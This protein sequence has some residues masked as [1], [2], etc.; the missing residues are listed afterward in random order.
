MNR[1]RTISAHA[2]TTLNSSRCDAPTSRHSR[3]RAHAAGRRGDRHRKLSVGRRTHPRAG[4][5]VMMIAARWKLRH[6]AELAVLLVLLGIAALPATGQRPSAARRTPVVV[7][8]ILYMGNAAE[9][10]AMA[11]HDSL[12]QALRM[13]HR[14]GRCIPPVSSPSRPH[15][16]LFGTPTQP[17]SREPASCWETSSCPAS[18]RRRRSALR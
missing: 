4:S 17:A 6:L 5:R 8:S 15:G 14:T 11:I 16:K 18:R 7:L 3:A 13:A 1:C 2:T 9:G 12:P 10:A